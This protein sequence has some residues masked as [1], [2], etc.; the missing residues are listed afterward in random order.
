MPETNPH[1]APLHGKEATPLSLAIVRTRLAIDRTALA[2]IR[3]TLGMAS[4]GFGMV[5]F[6]RSLQQT[7]QTP[8]TVRLFHGAIHFGT[9]LVILGTAATLLAALVQWCA[10]RDLARGNTPRTPRLP[11]SIAV[12]L[13]VSLLFAALLWELLRR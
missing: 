2:W 8:E 7:K 12:S 5:A 11:L 13:A 1:P 3:T 4:F 10:L 9:A 6:F